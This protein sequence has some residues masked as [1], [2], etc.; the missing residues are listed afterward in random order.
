MDSMKCPMNNW[1]IP[2][3]RR[4]AGERILDTAKRELYEETG[5]TD[6]HLRPV[7]VYSVERSSGDKSFGMLFFAEVFQIGPLPESEIRA[8]AFLDAMPSEMTYPHIQPYLL[9]KVME[10]QK[11]PPMPEA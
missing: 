6:F 2:G 8:V 4:E 7:A 9:E 5:A 11:I 3:G 10:Q 1:E